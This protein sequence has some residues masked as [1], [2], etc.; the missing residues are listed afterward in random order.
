MINLVSQALITAIQH[1]SIIGFGLQNNVSMFHSYLV[2][3]FPLWTQSNTILQRQPRKK[4]RGLVLPPV[5]LNFNSRTTTH[6]ATCKFQY[7]VTFLNAPATHLAQKARRH[8]P[9]HAAICVYLDNSMFPRIIFAASCCSSPPPQLTLKIRLRDPED[10]RRK[11]RSFC[12]FLACPRK[13]ME[14]IS[15]KQSSPLILN[16]QRILA[17]LSNIHHGMLQLGL[18]LTT[19]PCFLRPSVSADLEALSSS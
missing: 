6:K 4:P 17:P 3:M 1:N 14:A 9:K 5:K 13:H 12:L 15:P 18:S 7:N 19:L 11:M 10:R 16:Y 8:G 2:N